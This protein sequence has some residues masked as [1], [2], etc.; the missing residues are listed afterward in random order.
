MTVKS[1]VVFKVGLILAYWW[2]VIIANRWPVCELI[3]WIV[4]LSLLATIIKI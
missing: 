1:W 2:Y 3:A 4:A